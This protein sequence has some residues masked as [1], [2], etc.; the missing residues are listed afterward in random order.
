MKGTIAPDHIPRNKYK[1][2]VQGLPPITWTSVG[3]L[4]EELETVDIP[5]RTAAS[6]GNTKPVEFNVK[7]PTHHPAERIAMEN[8]FVE[9]QDPVSPQYKKIGTLIKTSISGLQSVTY[10]LQGLFVC[11]RVT[12]ELEM[13]NEGELDELEWTMK[14]DQIFPR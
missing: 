10:I 9:G 1:L 2:L 3:S 7:H 12:S 13:A 14:C 11:K 4:E 8:W 5:D 6:G